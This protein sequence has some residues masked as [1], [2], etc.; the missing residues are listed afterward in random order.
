MALGGDLKSLIDRLKEVEAELKS[1]DQAITNQRPRNLKLSPEQIREEVI[2]TMMRFR[3]TLNDAEVAVAR[4][5]LRKHVG[6]L[7]LTPTVKD[8]RRLFWVSGNV[9]PPPE[10]DGGVMQLV[11]RDGLEPPT[12]AFSGL[13]TDN[14]K[15]FRMS[16]GAW[17][18]GSY[19]KPLLGL[20]GI[21]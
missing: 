10:R 17:C 7:V 2:R 19:W 14:A 3:M 8:G 12:P 1:L 11:A 20:H 16:A 13:L 6:R 15:A 18:N 21:N 5:A 4:N 9:T